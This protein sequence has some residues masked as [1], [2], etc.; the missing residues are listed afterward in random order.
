M[1]CLILFL[2]VSKNNFAYKNVKEIKP[3][4]LELLI[5]FRHRLITFK[6]LRFRHIFSLKIIIFVRSVLCH[7]ADTFSN[8]ICNPL[9]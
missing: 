6:S 1:N 5:T 2:R 4:F 7:N 9:G 3:L 8:R